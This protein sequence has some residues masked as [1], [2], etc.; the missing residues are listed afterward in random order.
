[1][2]PKAR[3]VVL[4]VLAAAAAVLATACGPEPTGSEPEPLDATITV[5]AQ[6]GELVTAVSVEVSAADIRTP[7]V[8]NIPVT[9]G[10]ASG[11]VTVPAGSD[12]LLTVHAFDDNAIETH[13]GAGTV[14][15]KEGDNQVVEI[16]LDPLTGQQPIVATVGTYTVILE[17]ADTAIDVLDTMRLTVTVTDASGHVVQNPTLYW[18]S[19]N[20]VVAGIDDN[21]LVTGGHAGATSIVVSYLGVVATAQVV[22]AGEFVD[23]IVFT[24]YGVDDYYVHDYVMNADGSNRTRLMADAGFQEFEPIWSPDGSRIAL[25]GGTPTMIDGSYYFVVDLYVVAADGSGLTNLTNNPAIYAHHSWS[26]DGTKLAFTIADTDGNS[27]IYVIN[28]DGS[29]MV[30]L[31]NDSTIGAQNPAWSPDGTRIVFDA[32][33][34]DG[35]G[36]AREI[37][38]M[39]ADGSGV[40][41]VTNHA[42]YDYLPVWSPDGSRIAFAYASGDEQAIYTVNADGSGLTKTSP[43]GID[44]RRPVW[45][46]D[47][48]R[49]AFD[50]YITGYIRYDVYVMDADGTGVTNLTNIPG[51]DQL[52]PRWSPDGGRILYNSDQDGNEEIYVMN[53]D[54]TGQT[55]LTNDPASDGGARWG[56]VLVFQDPVPGP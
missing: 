43:A 36:G 8:A 11:S 46:P 19:M 56:R 20:P 28:A 48:T 31:T 23:R 21:G 41:R 12:R 29:G 6:V 38:V 18:G 35:S 34:D 16:T 27:D 52:V 39:N 25:R 14:N 30:N 26:P 54:G 55:N 53:P 33:V 10:V 17:P 42:D 22:V 37:F 40:V 44:A 47:G 3:L 4:T 50:A 2:C 45:S 24:S 1:M 51:S 49:I 13:R 7:I 32:M 9:D 5:S 15:L